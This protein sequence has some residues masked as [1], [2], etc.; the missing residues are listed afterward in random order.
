MI[1]L[2]SPREIQLMKEAGGLL[3]E[4]FIT[5][6]DCAEPGRCTIELDEVAEAKIRDGGARPAFK[7]YQGSGSAPF[8]GTAC[9]SIDEVVV[10]GIP[11]ERQ[12][13]TGQIVGVDIGLELNGWYADMAVSVLIGEVNADIRKLWQVTREALYIG[14]DQIRPGNRIRDIG[15]A[16]QE[17]VDS[18]GFG[19]IRDLVGH[20]IG[21]N[22]HEEPSI[23][24]YYSADA[25]TKIKPGMTLAVEPMIA[26]GDWRI[27]ITSDRWSAATRDSS[28]TAHFEHTILATEG[29]PEI[30]T[31]LPDGRDPWLV[32]TEQVEAN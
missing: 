6:L 31:L 20:G 29:D 13:Q 3:A 14:I 22:L 11:S 18:F 26:L 32:V 19:I 17:H 7:G 15:A 1:H 10:H 12:F 28:P 27:K 2:K 25:R 23:P 9:I 4:V 5:A 8:P 16:I 24:N 30:L 21:S